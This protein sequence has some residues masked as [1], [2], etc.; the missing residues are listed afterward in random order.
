M[1]VP[2]VEHLNNAALR[3]NPVVDQDRCV[4][5]LP[6]AWPARHGT[7]DIGESAQQFEVVEDCAAEAFRGLREAGPGVLDDLLEIR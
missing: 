7:A 3:V 6:N 5:Q 4:Y 2:E 1:A